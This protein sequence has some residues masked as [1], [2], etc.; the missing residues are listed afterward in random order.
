MKNEDGQIMGGSHLSSKL[1][2]E[3]VKTEPPKLLWC[4]GTDGQD[5]QE[6][7]L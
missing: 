3:G 4:S 1:K 2:K 6:M 7:M 5:D